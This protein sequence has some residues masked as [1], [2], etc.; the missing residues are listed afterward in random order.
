MVS[1]NAITIGKGLLHSK[2]I[3]QKA[4]AKEMYWNTR[5]AELS[6]KQKRIAEILKG[7]T[8]YKRK[9]SDGST[10][11]NMKKMLKKPMNTGKWF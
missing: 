4:S 3:R 1:R 6:E 9:F 2:S 11:A 5:E 8:N 10:L 7:S